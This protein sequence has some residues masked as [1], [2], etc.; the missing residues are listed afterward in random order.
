MR[1]VGGR[2]FEQVPGMGISYEEAANLV[3]AG[4]AEWGPDYELPPAFYLHVG[5]EIRGIHYPA[6][7]LLQVG[8]H[9]T[10]PEALQLMFGYDK[11]PGGAAASW[12]RGG[13]G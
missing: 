4:A 1:H 11:L 10:E 7:A 8:G 12:L 3:D 2:S 5:L 13:V 6:G 9:L